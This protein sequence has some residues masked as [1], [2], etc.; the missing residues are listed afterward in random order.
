M[1][2]SSF[3]GYRSSQRP[4]SGTTANSAR[5]AVARAFRGENKIVP[6]PI[7]KKPPS[8]RCHV[9][10]L[11]VA[12]MLLFV[13]AQLAAS[14]APERGLL[15]ASTPTPSPEPECF[16]LL[17]LDTSLTYPFLASLGFELEPKYPAL[18]GRVWEGVLVTT[19]GP[20]AGSEPFVHDTL[21]STAPNVFPDNIG[22]VGEEFC[23]SAGIHTFSLTEP[24]ATVTP[25][26]R[27]TTDPVLDAFL[28][29]LTGNA[30][31]ATYPYDPAPMYV[32]P[33]SLRSEALTALA[34]IDLTWT[35]TN[36][37]REVLEKFCLSRSTF[38]QSYVGLQDCGVPAA[39]LT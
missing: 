11:V 35:T 21:A 33:S 28:E 36:S 18:V 1:P 8:N 2:R 3:A 15:F 32:F 39:R 14:A 10:D 7:A 22:K 4:G 9:D 5:G 20:E 13:L 30:G 16:F 29:T 27:I 34:A 31:N 6:P 19:T 37:N 24:N 17:T 26:Q 23:L 38:S 12:S 25:E